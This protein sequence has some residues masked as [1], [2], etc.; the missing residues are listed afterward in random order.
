VVSVQRY[1]TASGAVRY[2]ARVKSHGLAV[3]S[4][5]FSRKADAVAWEQDQYR[6]LRSGKWLDPRRGRVPLEVVAVAWLASRATVKRQTFESDRGIWRNYIAPRWRSR[7]VVSITTADV[8]TWMAE[9][10]GG[11]LARS[12]VTR[13][14][15]TLRSLLAYAVTDGRVTVNVAAL[16]KAPTGGQ[17]RREGQ[18]LS[19]SELEALATA[20]NG[21][22][23]DL[24]MVL[25]L[26]GL[27]WG[28]V[29]GLQVGDRVSVPG[30]GLRLSRAVLCSNG[31][32]ALYVDTLKNRRARTVPLVAAVVPIVERW[33]AG[34]SAGEWLF[35]APAGGPLRETNWKR[36]VGWR[37][38]IAAIGR[39][40]L[41][42]HDLRHTAA[43]VWL[44]S[45]ADPKVVQRVLGHASAAMT[46]NLYG[47][48]IDQNLWAAAAQLGDISGPHDGDSDS[49]ADSADLKGTA[50]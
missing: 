48:L 38:A 35:S 41:R 3:A 27:R 6:R 24:I 26:E 22:Y 25:G 50:D 14:L 4:K 47:H 17:G 36:S 40:E 15:A 30:P 2:R 34:K 12:T 18:I 13:A 5:V 33:A 9:L 29:A 42:V 49:S 28:E 1:T 23:G 37:E 39:P 45:G 43:S 21:T 44:G 46:M 19:L 11:G 20:C 31:G 10:M 32:G 8:S 7:P 16:A